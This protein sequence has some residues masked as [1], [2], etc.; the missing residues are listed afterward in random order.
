VVTRMKSNMKPLMRAPLEFDRD[1][2]VNAVGV[3]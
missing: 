2:L 3:G 1:D